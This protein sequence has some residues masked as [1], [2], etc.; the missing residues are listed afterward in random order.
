MQKR[1]E[2]SGKKHEEWYKHQLHIYAELLAAHKGTQAEDNC[3][4][5]KGQK[6]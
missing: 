5:N 6:A 3:R 4:N 1:V 2:K